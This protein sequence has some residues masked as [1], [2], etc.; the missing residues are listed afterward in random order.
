MYSLSKLQV[1]VLVFLV[2]HSFAMAREWK[3]ATGGF[4]IEAELVEVDGASVQLRRTD[5]QVITVPVSQLSAVDQRFLESLKPKKLTGPTL[6]LVKDGKPASVIV[7]NG[8][9]SEGQTI[10]ATELQEHIQI[11]S[12]ATIPIVKENELSASDA[13]KVLILLGNSNRANKLGVN[14]KQ[15]EA[16][17]FVVKTTKQALILAGE[18]GGGG[19]NQRNGTLW[20][21]YDFLQ[22]ELGC[23]WLWPGD[24]GRVVP[25]HS[26]VT[27]GQLD[28]QETPQ[29]KVRGFRL[30]HQE[31]HKVAYEKEGLGKYLNFGATYDQLAEDERVWVRRMR[32][33]KSYRLSAG[34]AFTTWWKKYKETEP[35]LFAL[36]PNGTR[37]LRKKS[38]PVEFVKMCVSNP[39]LWEKQLAP[40]KKYANDGATGLSLNT[41]ENDGSGGFCVCARCQ[42][43]DADP[44]SSLA[45]LP[46]VE[47]G[48]DVDGAVGADQLPDSLSDRYARWFNELARKLSEFDPEGRVVAYAYSR[49]RSPP[50][51]LKKIEPNVWIG[52]VGFNGYPRNEE[53]R[54]MSQDE[55]TGW[56]GLG[57]TIFLRSNSMF[58]MG[59]GVPFVASKQIA[60][61]MQFQVKNGLSATDYDNLQGYWATSGPSYYL[62]ARM[63]WDS[64][65]DPDKVLDEYYNSFGPMSPMVEDYF[66]YWEDFTTRLGNDPKFIALRRTER[67]QA[68]GT[69]YSPAVLKK[70]E[71]ILARAKRV[72]PTATEA[73]RERFR[74]IELGL[75][76]GRLLA[77]A[78]QDGKTSNGPEGEKLLAFRK[79]VAAR[80]VI[81]VYWTTSK[82]MR[83]R[84]FD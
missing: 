14:T 3:A 55:W 25:Q 79:K 15:F 57:A 56:S 8:K 17:T 40:L 13:N 26:T 33:G 2:M 46:P 75:E 76:H 45:S 74:N 4:S 70:A 18:D 69:I 72:L 16:E 20:A 42:A 50:T 62:L 83:Y 77:E 80:N 34:H 84:V 66:N 54:K 22:D 67:L 51:K 65:A 36:Q 30:A 73:E 23:R 9:P 48:A 81:N 21:V 7:T 38:T 10:A 6:T 52:Y 29:I 61:D 49:Y 28:V 78:L 27:I 64:S 39:K 32:M 53:Y 59:E 71:T 43:W 47:D 31:K 24:I 1:V 11:M 58:Y 44:N 12:G 37:G 35:D 19:S 41:S 60:E 5:G 68:Y 82:E 63:L